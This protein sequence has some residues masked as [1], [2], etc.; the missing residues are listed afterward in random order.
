VLPDLVI[1]KTVP[2]S[3]Q[4]AVPS[5]DKQGLM[6]NMVLAMFRKMFPEA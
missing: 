6:Y 5:V 4:I 1:P 3:G 2:S